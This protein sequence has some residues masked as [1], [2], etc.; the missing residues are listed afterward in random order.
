MG[1]VGNEDNDLIGLENFPADVREHITYVRAVA[2]EIIDD[3][4]PIHIN[5]FTV[6]EE[7]LLEALQKVRAERFLRRKK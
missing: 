4:E 1:H 3:I 2:R 5:T 6:L 7:K